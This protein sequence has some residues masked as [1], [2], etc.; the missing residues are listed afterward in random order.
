MY[1]SSRQYAEQ[2]RKIGA[3]SSILEADPHKLVQL[4]LEGASTRLR[5]AMA[6]MER[7]DNA[8]KGKAISRTCDIISHLASSLEP[9]RGGEIADNLGALYDYILLRVTQGNLANDRQ[10]LE[11]ALDLL[12]QIEA[13]WSAIAHGTAAAQPAAG[14]HA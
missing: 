1:A 6:H 11:E 14:A 3:T 8:A 13:G 12:G 7:G 9:Q 4:L 2:Y 10:A 5:Q